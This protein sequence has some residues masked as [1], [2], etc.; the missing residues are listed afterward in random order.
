MFTPPSSGC[1]IRTVRVHVTCMN[2]HLMTTKSP[3]LCSTRTY[4]HRRVSRA[5]VRGQGGGGRQPGQAGPQRGR[6]CT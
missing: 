4:A 5:A 6:R 2:D 1:L 3:S